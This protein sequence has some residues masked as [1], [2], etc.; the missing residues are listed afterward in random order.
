MGSRTPWAHVE[1]Y[2]NAHRNT[3]GSYSTAPSSRTASVAGSPAGTPRRAWNGRLPFSQLSRTESVQSYEISAP[4]V[5][6]T[7]LALQFFQELGFSTE[8]QDVPKEEIDPKV[9]LMEKILVEEK[10]I[11]GLRFQQKIQEAEASQVAS[12]VR[13]DVM[14]K[15]ISSFRESR[16]VLKSINDN[17]DHII[18]E[19][20]RP[21]SENSIPVEAQDQEAFTRLIMSVGETGERMR[22]LREALKVTKLFKQP[23]TIWEEA[24]SSLPTT[25]TAIS[26]LHFS[27]SN[28]KNDVSQILKKT[29]SLS[30][31]TEKDRKT[32]NGTVGTDGTEGTEGTDGKGG[33]EGEEGKEGKEGKGKRERDGDVTVRGR[34]VEGDMSEDVT[35]VT[36]EWKKKEGREGEKGEGKEEEKVEEKDEG[37]VRQLIKVWGEKSNFS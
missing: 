31:A 37:V 32:E 12:L 29:S 13:R 20:Q 25:L 33:K 2:R 11:S 3:Y 30:L 6:G 1:E 14:E 5:N 4:T 36:S 18:S 22:D 23:P 28:V 16:D 35:N 19:L 8:S 7:D 10:K 24:N 9:D 21:I 15:L 27:V 26:N 17:K 34:S